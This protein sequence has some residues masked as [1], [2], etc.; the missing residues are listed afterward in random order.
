MISRRLLRDYRRLKLLIFVGFVFSSATVL[1]WSR[2]LN[3]RE[4]REFKTNE[5]E[6]EMMSENT[7]R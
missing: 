2:L 4:I 7:L 6:N 3:S 5:I 1:L